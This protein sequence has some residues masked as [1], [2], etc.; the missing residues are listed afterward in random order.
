MQGH[1][2]KRVHTTADGRTTTTWYVVVDR[3][4][5]RDGKRG[6]K[7]HGG[8]RTRREAE[9][10]QAKIV[11]QINT[12]TYISPSALA[13]GGYLTE[14]WIPGIRPRLKP[15]TWDSYRR[16]LELHVIPLIGSTPL[17]RISSTAL[18]ALYAELLR[19]GRCD[20]RG[21]LSERSVR[22]IHRILHKAFAD[23][24]DAQ[25]M[26]HNPA[27]RAKPPKANKAGVDELRLWRPEQLREFLEATHGARLHGIWILASMTGMRRGELLGL[28]W[29]DVDFDGCSLSITRTL[30][31][32]AYKTHVSTPK[33]GKPRVIDL[34]RGAI[35]VLR[36]ECGRRAEDREAWGAGHDDQGLVFA[37]EDGSPIHPDALTKA[38]DKEVER[39]GL[40]RIR[41]HDLRHTH[42]SIALQAGVPVKVISERLGHESPAFTLRQYAHVMP[43][44]QAEAASRVAQTVFCTSKEIT[45]A[46][47]EANVCST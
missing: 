45:C 5:D 28:R 22:Y 33:T 34:D 19:D 15:T 13:L 27:S 4:R 39:S 43:G 18:N 35:D 2:H 14:E 20:G 47:R 32:V 11:N 8:F 3:G 6:Q 29:S 21:G 16:N 41:L 24:L 12:G 37:R 26:S 38:F 10:A 46:Q 1:I 9:V 7:W 40:P 17:Q 25:L 42:A 30:V 44:M 23:A 31:S 36:E